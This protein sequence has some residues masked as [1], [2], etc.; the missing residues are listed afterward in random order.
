[1]AWL[2]L[3]LSAC[4]SG[5]GGNSDSDAASDSDPVTSI[6][7]PTTLNDSSSS[8]EP[9][10]S[11]TTGEPDPT[12]SISSS[13][14]SDLLK[15]D[16]FIPPAIEPVI[17]R[18]VLVLDK[19]G[20]MLTLWDHDGDG[21]T[22]TVTRWSSLHAVVESILTG[23]DSAVNFGALLFPALQ[24]TSNPNMTACIVNPD[25]LV[26]V[27]PMAA[28]AILDA[29]P[30]ADTMTIAGGTPS[31]EGILAAV[32]ELSGLEGD[33]PKFIIFITDGAANCDPGQDQLFD[34]YDD[35]LATAVAD[36][37]TAGFP[38]H[39]VGI[40]ILNELTP[41]EPGGNPDGINPYEKLNELAEIAG[42]ARDGAEKFYNATNQIELQAALMEITKTVLSC[43][44]KLGEPV[45]ENFYIQ[46]V[47]VGSDQDP[48]KLEYIGEDDQVS[49]C[50]AEGGWQYTSEARDAIILCGAACEHYKATGHVEIDYGCY[51]G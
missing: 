51:I 42:T 6:L 28:A 35:R 45:P 26:P 18:V 9:T 21:A 4:N 2:A 25:P 40:D 43:E 32:D 5:G 49:D 36:A 8:G 27:G 50:E 24:A 12:T 15:C 7:P 31:T 22:D 39:V 48:D 1:M 30:A 11:T 37:R 46:R 14:T 23:L 47:Q 33:E 10:T 3:L 29:I 34:D 19:S 20:S 41:I 13:T 44:I 16:E 38:T 17:P